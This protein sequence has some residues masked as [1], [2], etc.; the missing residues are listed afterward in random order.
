MS[1]GR[2]LSQK[3]IVNY[4]DRVFK[5]NLQAHATKKLR[6]KITQILNYTNTKN[7]YI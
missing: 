6:I 7:M 4:L 2:Q 1:Q 3:H 5:L